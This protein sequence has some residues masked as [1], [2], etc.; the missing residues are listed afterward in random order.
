MCSIKVADMKYV[1]FSV[2]PVPAH[3]LS[4]PECDL[5]HIVNDRVYKYYGHITSQEI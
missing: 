1:P 4:S 2:L 3:L 5:C